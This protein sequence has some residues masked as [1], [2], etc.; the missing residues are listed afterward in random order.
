MALGLLS[1]H[2]SFTSRRGVGGSV[3]VDE[4]LAAGAAPV[5]KALLRISG[6]A[7]SVWDDYIYLVG[8]KRDNDALR[9]RVAR[10]MEENNRLKEELRLNARLRRILSFRKR[11]SP[12]TVASEILG[13]SGLAGGGWTRTITLDKGS[14]DGIGIDMPVLSPDG[15]VGRIIDTTR[16]T[17][18]ALLL[19]DPRSNIDVLVQ[20][21]RVKGVV[22]GN[23]SGGLTLKYVTE[24]DDVRPGD[25]VITA[26]LSGIFPKGLVIGEVT[27][28]EKGGDNF[29][30]Y[31][32][33]EPGVDIMRLE[34]VLI[35]TGRRSPLRGSPARGPASG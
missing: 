10:L 34:E 24:I 25:K 14:A 33:V 16:H 18:V 28:V 21:T 15:V 6:A 8:L 30:K 2:L 32:E 23:G 22:E 20:R 31:I 3:I 26:G 12:R 4:V 5:Q 13:F 35:D 19:T 29:F 17:A 27:T 1:L 7:A 9:R 11:T